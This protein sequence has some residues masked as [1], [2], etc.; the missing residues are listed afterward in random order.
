M[1]PIL[2]CLSQ[3]KRLTN[4]F[5]NEKYKE[6][7]I[8]NN[9][10]LNNKNALQLSPFYLELIQKLWDINGPKS[11]SPNKIKNII[12]Q[13]NPS[14]KEGQAINAKDFIDY[15]LMKL[16]QELYYKNKNQKIGPYDPYNQQNS[17]LHSI[18]EFQQK[19]SI[20]MIVTNFR[21]LSLNIF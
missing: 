14:F 7:I 8:N 13:M 16:H 10:A 2:Q 1:N 6:K 5:L 3:T 11:F 17:L 19:G 12:E 15:I 4:Y 18:N 20:I 21:I 9:I